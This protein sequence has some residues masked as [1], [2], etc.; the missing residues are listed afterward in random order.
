ME[1]VAKLSLLIKESLSIRPTISFTWL[2][3]PV[4]CELWIPPV[5]PRWAAT[6]ISVMTKWLIWR[7]PDSR[8]CSVFCGLV[9]MLT[10]MVSAK[11]QAGLWDRKTSVP[12]E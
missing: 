12:A 5:T 10:F 11:N 4:C 2:M 7:G 9:T 8:T 6:M 3:V 1:Q